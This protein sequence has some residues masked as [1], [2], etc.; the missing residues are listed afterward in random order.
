MR[1]ASFL[2]TSTKPSTLLLCLLVLLVSRRITPNWE[3]TLRESFE[4]GHEKGREEGVEKGRRQEKEQ[5][6]LSMLQK[7][8]ER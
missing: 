3:R 6:A 4:E 8:M 7:G 1:I 5:I 2:A